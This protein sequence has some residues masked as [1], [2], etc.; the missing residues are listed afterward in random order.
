MVPLSHLAN[1]AGRALVLTIALILAPSNALADS[2]YM[3]VEHQPV[4]PVA[5]RINDVAID[6]SDA[7]HVLATSESGG[8]WRSTDR[9]YSWNAVV[10][11]PAFDL[12]AVHFLTSNPRVVVVTA[13]SDFAVRRHGSS[14]YQT[15]GGGIWISRDGGVTWTQ[16]AEAIAAIGATLP[17]GDTSCHSEPEAFGIDE[18]RETRRLFVTTNCGVSYSDDLGTRADARWRH[19]FFPR[20]VFAQTE[21]VFA[22]VAALEGSGVVAIGGAGTWRS[23]NNGDTWS[24]ASTTLRNAVDFHGATRVDGLANAGLLITRDGRTRHLYATINNGETWSEITSAPPNSDLSGGIAHIHAI[25]NDLG[26]QLYYGN[27]YWSFERQFGPRLETIRSESWSRLLTSHEDTRAMAFGTSGEPAFVASDG[28]LDRIASHRWYPI[29]SGPNRINALQLYDIEGQFD[30]DTGAYRIAFGTQDNGYWASPDERTWPRDYISGTE[31]GGIQMSRETSGDISTRSGTG[32]RPTAPTWLPWPS[33]TVWSKSSADTWT[34]TTNTATLIS[35]PYFLGWTQWPGYSRRPDWGFSSPR[36]V[37]APAQGAYMHTVFPFGSGWTP[38]EQGGIELTLD[39]GETYR[40]IW[41]RTPADEPWGDPQVAG[42][43]MYLAALR[44]ANAERIFEGEFPF[45]DVELLRVTNALLGERPSPSFPAMNGFGG[46]GF[47]AFQFAINPVYAVN[48][49]NSRH[50][51]APDA[52]ADNAIKKSING[53]D[54]WTPI[55]GLT[56]AVSHGGSYRLVRRM[57]SGDFSLTLVTALS[58]FPENPDLIVIGTAMGGARISV[59]GGET[60]RVVEGSDRIHNI[61]DFHWKSANEIYVASYGRGLW[62]FAGSPFIFE[63]SD[64]ERLYCK[65]GLCGND[66]PF[67]RNILFGESFARAAAS[68]VA[69]RTSAL[70]PLRDV[71]RAR[72]FDAIV[73]VVDGRIQGLKKGHDILEQLD[74]SPGSTVLTF[75]RTGQRSRAIATDIVKETIAKANAESAAAQPLKT[76]KPIVKGLVLKGTRVTAVIVGEPAR[77]RRLQVTSETFPKV[78][79]KSPQPSFEGGHLVLYPSGPVTN[80][81]P[82]YSNKYPLLARGV[83]FSPN[84]P[85]SISID[86]REVTGNIVADK[87]GTFSIRAPLAAL[88]PGLHVLRAVQKRAGTQPDTDERVF[89]IRHD[90]DEDEKKG[91]R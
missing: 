44:G 64:F 76:P 9:G 51:I 6:P 1:W 53:G 45:K 7:S 80:N 81:G 55:A 85:V 39:Y 18:D 65:P 2:T 43:T 3:A 22:A 60:W 38:E 46:L 50:L 28:G 72:D 23:T 30:R 56:E 31:G 4:I 52:F 10:A 5:G 57:P 34:W 8:L 67:L 42:N 89:F 37:L 82:A 41:R 29:G 36:K 40:R 15:S 62:R 27:S 48:P 25:R 71:V 54:V 33:A 91:G 11:L 35:S 32:T 58:F 24:P 70:L 12:N 87:A 63:L 84:T 61:L 83:A 86:N 19:S 69:T 26:Y 14:G 13:R 73:V 88:G 47:Y 77:H 17:P 49:N 21:R 16:P 75:S 59:N 74:V 66:P 68:N 20:P 79:R 90:E 78:E